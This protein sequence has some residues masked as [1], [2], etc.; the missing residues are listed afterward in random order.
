M[1]AAEPHTKPVRI[2]LA[3]CCSRPMSSDLLFR[4]AGVSIGGALVML[5]RLYRLLWKP[6][7]RRRRAVKT[8]RH[9]YRL[10]GSAGEHASRGRDRDGIRQ[11]LRPVALRDE[12]NESGT[13]SKACSPFFCLAWW[14]PSGNDGMNRGKQLG[15]GEG[16]VHVLVGPY[17]TDSRSCYRLIRCTQDQEGVKQPSSP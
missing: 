13:L 2:S 16:L 1:P 15:K 9:R 7:P 14:K 11:G 10:S 6:E 4:L 17:A 5:C 8:P 3:R 12:R